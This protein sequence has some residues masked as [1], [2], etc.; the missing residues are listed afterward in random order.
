MK[1]MIKVLLIVLLIIVCII[2]FAL[3]FIKIHKPFGASPNKKDFEDYAKRS[4]IFKDGKFVNTGN[5]TVMSSWNDPYKDRTTGKGL[6]PESEIPYVDYKYTENNSDVLIT[7]F[8]HSSVLIQIGGKNILVDPIFEE[9]A[10]PVSFTGSHRYSHI[11]VKIE[12]LPQ[13]DVILLTHDHY[14]H[15]S[16]KTLTSLENKTKKLCPGCVET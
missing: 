16:Y 1:K 11:P 7:W 3:I 5:F 10:S 2:V 14:D 4:E 12:D 6:K 8:G 9:L 13:I 15:V